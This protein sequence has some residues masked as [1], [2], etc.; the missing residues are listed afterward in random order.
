MKRLTTPFLGV[1]LL[2]GAVW[3]AMQSYQKNF[4]GQ[5]LSQFD[6]E[7]LGVQLLEFPRQLPPL[8]ELDE[9]KSQ[10]W[11]AL[12]LKPTVCDAL[13]QGEIAKFR[14]LGIVIASP[15]QAVYQD[16]ADVTQADGYA[17]HRDNVLLINPDGRFAGSISG[18]YDA[19]R[20]G[21]IFSTLN[22]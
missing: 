12:Q 2:A 7:R 5:A 22:K 4:A 14:D 16:L 6:Q 13:C 11:F 1:A 17:N 8:G 9:A 3:V 20:L 10:Q 21:E 19:S 15:G 18:P